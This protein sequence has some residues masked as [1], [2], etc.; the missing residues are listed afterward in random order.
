VRSLFACLETASNQRHK[1]HFRNEN[2]SYVH[3]GV[4]NKHHLLSSGCASF[5][6]FRKCLRCYSLRCP[7]YEHLFMSLQVRFFNRLP[8][9]LESPCPPCPAKFILILHFLKMA[10]KLFFSRK[11]IF[12]P[13]C[14]KSYRN[15]KNNQNSFYWHIFCNSKSY[16]R[17]CVKNLTPGG[18][19]TRQKIDAKKLTPKLWRQ[20]VDG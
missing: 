12:F 14:L 18:S 20:K 10:V 3:N 1:N 9:C 17:G 7:G 4:K 8:F 6:C 15:N 16:A 13:A 19:L 11:A 5:R 2:H